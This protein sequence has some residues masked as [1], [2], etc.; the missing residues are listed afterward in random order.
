MLIS[1]KT[2]LLKALFKIFWNLAIIEKNVCSQV[3]R[4]LSE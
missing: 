4:S 2:E 3:K 1:K